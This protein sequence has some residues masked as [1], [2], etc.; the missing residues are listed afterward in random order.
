[1][2]FAASPGCLRAI[3]VRVPTPG[4]DEN[5]PSGRVA[6]NGLLNDQPAEAVADDHRLARKRRGGADDVVDIGAEAGPDQTPRAASM[7]R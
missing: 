5:R 6:R 7:T 4:R 2:I 3:E 1:M